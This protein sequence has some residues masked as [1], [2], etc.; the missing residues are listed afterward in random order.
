MPEEPLKG[1][2]D[3]LLF[4]RTEETEDK[5]LALVSFFELASAD[6]WRTEILHFPSAKLHL[7]KWK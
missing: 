3:Q 4:I 2:A 5:K 6:G 1:L 7:I